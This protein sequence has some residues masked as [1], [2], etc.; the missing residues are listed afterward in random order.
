MFQI[1]PEMNGG[2]DVLFLLN[3]YTCVDECHDWCG[4]VQWR[5]LGLQLFSKEIAQYGCLIWHWTT[6]VSMM[7]TSQS[8]RQL[9][10]PFDFGWRYTLIHSP[11]FSSGVVLCLLHAKTL[12]LPNISLTARYSTRDVDANLRPLFSPRYNELA[13]KH[14]SKSKS[15]PVVILTLTYL[16]HL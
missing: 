4:R 5:S 3:F 6:Q 11:F 14:I 12:S 15:A 2:R 1:T 8:L 7:V 13:E 16:L 10:R 9:R